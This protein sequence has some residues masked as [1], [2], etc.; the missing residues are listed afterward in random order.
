MTKR[1]PVV[2]LLAFA[3]ALAALASAPAQTVQPPP[4]FTALFNGRDLSGWQGIQ[5]DLDP[6]KRQ[7]LLGELAAANAD[8]VAWA[9]SP[10]NEWM[11]PADKLA[12]YRA[13]P[14]AKRAPGAKVSP[15][16]CRGRHGHE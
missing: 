1:T 11:V 3:S 13:A 4:G 8:V 14:P 2:A 6:R 12:A 5:R 9:D 15:G 10:A 7:E 16:D